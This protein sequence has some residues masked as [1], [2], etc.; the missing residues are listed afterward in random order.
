[1]SFK[2]EVTSKFI[3]QTKRLSKKY[4]SLKQDV[5]NLFKTLYTDPKQG[6]PI[7]Q[8]C[9]KI[10]LAITSKKKGKSGGAR[11]ITHIQIVQNKIYILSIYDKAEQNTISPGDIDGLLREI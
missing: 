9:Y 10:R 7:G 2:I 5:E 3:K 8:N 4:P 6:T 1:M 11:V